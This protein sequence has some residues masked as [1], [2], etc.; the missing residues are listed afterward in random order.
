[1]RH[2]FRLV[3][4]ETRE[5]VFQSNSTQSLPYSIWTENGCLRS[6]PTFFRERPCLSLTV[7]DVH[8]NPTHIDFAEEDSKQS[9]LSNVAL[10]LYF[11]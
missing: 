11:F 8:N 10:T 6:F 3:A 9:L 4:I 1:M 2:S 5:T 7:Q